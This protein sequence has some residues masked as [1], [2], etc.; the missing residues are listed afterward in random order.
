[1]LN[2]PASDLFIKDSPCLTSNGFGKLFQVMGQMSNCLLVGL[3]G[4]L[5]VLGWLGWVELVG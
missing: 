5:V 1:M 2:G 3:V 4:W